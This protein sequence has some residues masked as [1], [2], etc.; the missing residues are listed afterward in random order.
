M[1]LAARLFFD[2]RVHFFHIFKVLYIAP[3]NCTK[4][5]R[6]Q[7]T[8]WTPCSH[9][10]HHA[11]CTFTATMSTVA[12][13]PSPPQIEHPPP[14]SFRVLRDA[15][16]ECGGSLAAG[17]FFSEKSA[18]FGPQIYAKSYLF[19][20]SIVTSISVPNDGIYIC[21]AQTSRRSRRHFPR[22]L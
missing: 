7:H 4:R 13:P 20:W 2:F 6:M 8:E 9:D 1:S 11:A 16:S 17:L 19:I 14:L 18:F 21:E 5:R 15:I 22:R 3:G 12:A 10:T